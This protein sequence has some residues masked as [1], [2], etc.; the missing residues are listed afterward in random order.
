MKGPGTR[1]KM[2]L[3]KMRE[4]QRLSSKSKKHSIVYYLIGLRPNLAGVLDY[5]KLCT[6][7]LTQYQITVTEDCH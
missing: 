2:L 4:S 7:S 6:Y 1:G 5:I 3:R